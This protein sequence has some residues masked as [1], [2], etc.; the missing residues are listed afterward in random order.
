MHGLWEM[1]ELQLSRAHMVL[2]TKHILKIIPTNICAAFNSINA[3]T[4]MILKKIEI[5]K[6]LF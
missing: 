3:L 6:V 2:K 1:K 5:K 4:F